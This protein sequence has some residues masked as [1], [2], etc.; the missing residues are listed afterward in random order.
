MQE[1]D[2]YSLI[3]NLLQ[4]PREKAWLEYKTNIAGSNASI[5]NKQ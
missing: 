1:K 4:D 3:D 5:T 2:L